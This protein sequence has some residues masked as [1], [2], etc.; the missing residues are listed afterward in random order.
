MVLDSFRLNLVNRNGEV[1]Q[2]HDN[3]LN[4]LDKMKNIGDYTMGITESIWAVIPPSGCFRLPAATPFWSTGQYRRTG[5][6]DAAKAFL[7]APLHSTSCCFCCSV[8]VFRYPFT[9][10]LSP[11]IFWMTG[12]GNWIVSVLIGCAAGPFGPPPIWEQV[13][14]GEA[15]R[16][17]LHLPDR[18]HDQTAADGIP[19]S[20]CI[21]RHRGRRHHSECV[22]WRGSG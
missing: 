22:V 7:E 10:R 16:L 15:G 13:G 14:T 20:F 5:L 18:Q 11:F 12:I 17:R 8:P 2:E 9:R 1:V 6:S 4:P 21:G 19:D 3:Q